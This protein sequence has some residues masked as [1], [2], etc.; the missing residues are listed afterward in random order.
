MMKIQKVIEICR[1]IIGEKYSVTDKEIDNAIS[2][3]SR[4]YPN[5]SKDEV[6]LQLLSIY[7][8]PIKPYKTLLD[9]NNPGGGWFSFNDFIRKKSIK[10]DF[11]DRYVRY[12]KT[13]EKYQ[14]GVIHQLDKLTDE[15][16]DNLFDPSLS[17]TNFAKK[18]LVVGQVQSSKTP[19]FIGLTCKAVDSGYNVIIVFAGTLD[20][21]RT[22][23][24]SRL[25][26]C[27]LGFTTK[28]IKK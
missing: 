4:I 1:T 13:I 9:N 2:L 8:L 10:W 11:W 21:L 5:I 26:K 27:F 20:D 6:K 15:I 23:T 16:L 28:D 18:G 12:L 25:E 24:Q 17:D 3:A 7:S 19:N 22:Q 14:P